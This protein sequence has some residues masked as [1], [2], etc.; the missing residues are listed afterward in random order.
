VVARP[1]LLVCVVLA[2]GCGPSAQTPRTRLSTKEL[3]TRFKPSVVRIE[4]RSQ[5]GR[6]AQGSGFVVGQDG[7]IATN[8]HV[9]A[10]ADAIEVKLV[11]GTA[12]PVERVVAVDIERDLAILA[13]RKAGLP[14]VMLGDSDQVS[15]GDPVVAIGNPLGVF[16]FTVS[17]GLISSVRALSPELVALQISAPISQGSSGGPLFNNYGEVIGVATFIAREGQLLNFGV[18]ANYLKPLLGRRGGES[19]PRFTARMQELV[20]REQ[21]GE[22]DAAPRGKIVRKI[23]QHDVAILDGCTDDQ[24]LAVFRAISEAIERGAPIYN[25]GEHEACFVIYRKV[26]DRF[27]DDDGMCKCVRQ[28][29]GEG[30]LRGEATEDFT[31]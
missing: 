23:P 17:D 7:R 14:S 25:E 29:F 8:L 2:L 1:A 12:Y 19:V 15:A 30:L 3:V 6:V 21:P 5:G 27:D 16:D 18:P 10:G 28:A 26:A 13:I 22:G 24:L 4:A 9:I 11:D 31:G 20:T